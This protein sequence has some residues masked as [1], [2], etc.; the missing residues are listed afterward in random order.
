MRYR[1][2][3]VLMGMLGLCWPGGDIHAQY[4]PR[5]RARRPAPTVLPR[6]HRQP[7][8]LPR[9]APSTSAALG[10]LELGRQLLSHSEYRAALS[11]LLPLTSLSTFT[12]A[13]RDTLL[14]LVATAALRAGD[15]ATAQRVVNLALSQRSTR[16]S[17][18][19]QRVVT[20]VYRSGPG[21]EALTQRIAQRG[22]RGALELGWLADVYEELGHLARAV[23]FRRANVRLQPGNLDVHLALLRTLEVSGDRA[24]TLAEREVFVRR[25]PHHAE[26]ALILA[27]ELRQRGNVD[28]ADA[29]LT[30]IERTAGNESE[31][32]YRV[33]DAW[34]RASNHARAE[35]LLER[36]AAATRAPGAA[37]QTDAASLFHATADTVGSAKLAEQL[38]LA[39]VA[40]TSSNVTDAL[41][42]LD[43]ARQSPL[44]ST[45]GRIQVAM[46]LERAAASATKES[47]ALRE[48]AERH[49][50]SLLFS[51]SL[52]EAQART[53]ID[54]AVRLWALQGKLSEHATML[55][56]RFAQH[57]E[58][59]TVG[60]WLAEAQVRLERYAAAERTLLELNRLQPDDAATLQRLLALA[61]KRGD[62]E[63]AIEL[64]ELRI[65][66]QPSELPEL[67][68]QLVGY[69]ERTRR[70]DLA[71]HYARRW[72][73]AAPND[74]NAWH[75]YAKLLRRLD[76]RAPEASS[77]ALRRAIDLAPHRTESLLELAQWQTEDGEPAQA[78]ST[79]LAV[80]RQCE[81]ES[82]LVEAA[83]MTVALATARGAIEA[84][85]LA[86]RQACARMPESRALRSSLLDTE[87]VLIQTAESLSAPHATDVERRAISTLAS[88][89]GDP[90][91][92]RKE[93]I[94]DLLTKTGGSGIGQELLSYAKAPG[95]PQSRARAVLLAARPPDAK[96][97]AGFVAILQPSGFFTPNNALAHASAFGVSRIRNRAATDVLRALLRTGTPELRG[98][99]ALWLAERQDS[100]LSSEVERLASD[101]SAS[102][103][104]RA[105]AELA[106][107]HLASNR[108]AG[109]PGA[110][111]S[112]AAANGADAAMAQTSVERRVQLAR[113]TR[114]GAKVSLDTVSR[115]LAFEVTEGNWATATAIAACRFGA[116][117]P[118]WPRVLD[119]ASG[120]DID[121]TI[122]L[123]S[124]CEMTRHHQVMLLSELAVPLGGALRELVANSAERAK[125]IGRWLTSNP[126]P[127]SAADAIRLPASTEPAALSSEDAERKALGEKRLLEPVAMEFGAWL[128]H[129]DRELRAL[130]VGIRV[131]VL[132]DDR[133]LLLGLS[134]VDAEN[135]RKA[136][137]WAKHCPTAHVLEAISLRMRTDDDFEVRRQ[138]AVTLATLIEPPGR[139]QY[140]AAYR[141]AARRDPFA[142]VRMAALSGLFH[143]NPLAA[144]EELRYA[145]SHDSEPEVIALAHKLR[146]HHP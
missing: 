91:E 19:L 55:A 62:L 58:N 30:H 28:A 44:L 94:L 48:E 123:L 9:V 133:A 14:S 80:L 142:S 146:E 71:R 38:R 129:S 68:R 77:A 117:E 102:P 32:L 115:L 136:L 67:T 89:L 36:L 79:A 137:A 20:D 72:V 122:T 54:H 43:S 139:P 97:L 127:L 15:G 141:E 99:A 56:E 12:Q 120:R 100:A 47:N 23:E 90:N 60:W 105:A 65:Q 3:T 34:E 39:E 96:L 75:F 4:H 24:A 52:S 81:N 140:I 21:L 125:A 18:E 49:W 111:V 11:T 85:E 98:W 107:L 61:Q 104:T 101:S 63:R 144:S 73:D 95:N 41:K 69:A 33:V 53:C 126:S 26:Q 138:A 7:E 92:P 13:E 110:A 51:A 119:T 25:F 131:R 50:T 132:G 112:S 16:P 22:P 84:A 103:S 2:A 121:A 118:D 78:F 42:H 114:P 93:Y 64:I 5:G 86:L 128:S 40:I 70:D 124:R 17:D 108:R 45:R 134:D 145:E 1:A 87:A 66:H 10:Q 59:R 83:R 113:A 130:A 29:L 106:S 35:R 6:E 74:P 31:L 8:Q 109:R 27:N 143:T 46:L 135:R 116:S 76:G 57:P 37:P 82:C 88:A